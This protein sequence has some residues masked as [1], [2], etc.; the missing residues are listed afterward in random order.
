MSVFGHCYTVLITVALSYALK[1]GSIMPLAFFRPFLKIAFAV[2]GLFQF[3]TKS[4]IVYPISVKMPL[5]FR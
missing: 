4:R 3:H 1:L 2:W 5:E